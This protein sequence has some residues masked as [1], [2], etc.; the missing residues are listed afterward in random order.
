MKLSSDSV[1][2]SAWTC[3]TCYQLWYAMKIIIINPNSRHQQLTAD[4]KS[5]ELVTRP[6][7]GSTST[8]MRFQWTCSVR[9]SPISLRCTRRMLKCDHWVVVSVPVQLHSS[10]C[11]T[12]EHVTLTPLCVACRYDRDRHWRG[13][14]PAGVQ[15][16]PRRLLLWLQGHR[17]RSQADGSHQL[18]GEE[19]EK[20]IGL[21]LRANC[22]GKE[23]VACEPEVRIIIN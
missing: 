16:W 13:V 21:D 11:V 4:R 3:C 9:E 23:A 5:S 10:P 22:W 18:P 1:E 14:R 15:V 12:A 17:R 20:E 6:P 7:T 2:E 19:S 8:V